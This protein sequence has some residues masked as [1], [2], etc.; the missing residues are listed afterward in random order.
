MASRFK[1]TGFTLVGFAKEADPASL[2]AAPK[3]DPT[4]ERAAKV[5]IARNGGKKWALSLVAAA[6]ADPAD[7]ASPLLLFQAGAKATRAAA[8]RAAAAAGRSKVV[9][10]FPGD[11]PSEA[12]DGG[13]A[14]AAAD[15]NATA[16]A[17]SVAQPNVVINKDDRQLI[18]DT[19]RVNRNFPARA[20]GQIDFSE[21]NGGNSIC[22]GALIGA[23]TVLTAGHCVHTGR[24][25]GF[26]RAWAF[27]PG[28]TTTTATSR[29]VV[30]PYGTVKYSK[31]VT[32]N[33]WI[34]AS[35]FAYDL[36]VV[37]LQ[38]AIGKTTGNLG[39]TAS[40]GRLSETW[41][42]Y[43]YPGE[44]TYGS[45]WTTSCGVND[46]VA[47]DGITEM[48]CD[49]TGGQSGSPMFISGKNLVKA[50]ISWS[51]EGRR[52]NGACQIDTERFNMIRA[53]TV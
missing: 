49:V 17:G 19:S 15:A 12:A 10:P 28:R 36:G 21:R 26:V 39:Y 53:N 47:T 27:S 42:T 24:G 31:L 9:A 14:L 29:T 23:S 25:G 37:N 33:G 13:A 35:S 6:A 45:M 51:N 5:E 3:F 48:T 11:A 8:A 40:T 52:I 2:A 22:S 20:V 32:T 34:T 7:P 1:D 44:K 46:N 4:R 30:N 38:S 16:A 41:T 50:V 18:T 43:G